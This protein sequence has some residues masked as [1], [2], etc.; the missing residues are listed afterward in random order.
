MD[1]TYFKIIAAIIIL[2]TAILGGIY[3]FK[4]SFA[5]KTIDFP[6]GEAFTSGIFLGAGLIHMLTDASARF[7]QAGFHYPMAAT[8][9]GATIIILL[10]FEHIGT[11]LQHHNK[12]TSTHIA[13]LT[14]VLLSIH[15]LFAGAAIGLEQHFATTIL[16]LIAILSHKWAASFA[17]SVEINKSTFSFKLKTILFIIFAAMTPLGIFFGSQILAFTNHG[18]I[19]PICLSIAAG[20]F[21]YIGTL[22]GLA[23][24]ILDKKCCDL[25]E[26]SFVILGFI[27][28]ALI[29][30]WV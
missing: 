17:L 19:E 4:K 28:M 30:I 22:H 11:E 6:I 12:S 7:K 18:L 13:I 20:T 25:K 8:I 10:L 14:T 27:L 9:C 21:I 3:P 24:T 1:L 16:I 23:R 5:H 15:S 2:L 29:A 26:F